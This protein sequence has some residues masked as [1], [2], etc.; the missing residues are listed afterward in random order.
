MAFLQPFM[1]N[2][3]GAF[4]STIAFVYISYAGVTK[5]AAIAGE[6]KN[7]SK[8][9]PLAMILSLFIISS[10]YIAITYTLVG[11]VPLLEL[12]EDI[13][14]IYTLSLT[15]GSPIF[16]YI[17]AGLGV[18]TLISMANSGV[19]ASSRFPFAMA[20]DKLLPNNLTKIHNKHLTP[21]N[22][23]LITCLMMAL[24]I[25][26]LDVEKIVK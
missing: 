13:R 19:L 21:I 9:L 2:G 24:V 25:L 10:V 4:L 23:I 3:S 18:A 26:F 15:L 22:T 14:P 11:N 7:P 6:V 1:N 12:N 16:A 5:I 20:M 17:V 8:N